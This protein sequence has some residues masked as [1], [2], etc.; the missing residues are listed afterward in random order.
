MGCYPQFFLKSLFFGVLV[1]GGGIERFEVGARVIDEVDVLVV[2]GGPGGIGAAISAARRGMRTMLVERFGCLG[3]VGTHCLVGIWLGSYS[4]DGAYPVIGGVFD[5][6]VERMAAEGGAIRARDDVVGGTRHLGY[7][8]WHGRTVPFEYECC[9]RVT[10]RTVLEAGVALRYFT[11]MIRPKVVGDRVAGVFVHSVDGVG[12]I[13]AK[14]VVDATGDGEV[15]SLAGC[16]MVKGRKEDG[17]MSGA[18][19]IFVVEDVDS[20]AF[21]RHARETGDVRFRQAIEEYEKE[22]KWP[23]AFRHINCCEMVRRGSF[24]INTGQVLGIDGTKAEDLTRGMVEGREQ[25][26]ALMEMLKQLVPGFERARLTQTAPMLGVRDTRRIAGRYWVTV[27]DVTDGVSFA[28]TVALSGYQWDMA[29]PKEPSKQRMKG[30]PIARPYAEIPYRSLLPQGME[31]LIV[32]GR[33]VSCDWDVLG[34]F[35]I[36][37]ACVAMGQAAGTAAAMAVAKGVGMG[38][39]DVAALRGALVDDGAILAR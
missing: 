25:A 5:E 32:A 18:T 24:F 19:L 20:A 23:F 28:D 37:P 26:L 30:R 29:D 22:A 3:G 36:M 14:V 38:Q 6:L 9:K 34:L 4:R 35:R 31:N 10:E 7:A 8:G 2:G 27:D 21:E 39:V 17:L 16:P 13:G 12:Y 11:T 33:T 15:A 1:M